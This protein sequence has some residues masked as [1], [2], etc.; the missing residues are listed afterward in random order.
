MGITICQQQI[1]IAFALGALAFPSANAIAQTSI[2][3]IVAGDDPEYEIDPIAVGNT[4]RISPRVFVSTTYD[5][6]VT[7]NPDGSEIQDFEFIVRPELV[8]SVVHRDMRFELEGY[9]EFSRFAD[10]TSENS[11]TYGVSGNFSHSPS[12]NQRLSIDAGYARQKENRGDPEAR[13]EEAP[14]PRLFDNTFASVDYRLSGGRVLLALEAAYSNLDAISSVDAD[15]D[16]ETYAGSATAGYRVSG[17]VYAT[18]TGF[19]TARDFRLPATPIDPDRDATTYGAQIGVNFI[20]SERLRGRARLGMF[21]F[22]PSDASLDGRTGFSADVSLTYLPRRRLALIL[23][24]FNGDVATFRRGAQA[25][26]DTRVSLT[27]QME[28]RHNFYART[29]LRWVQNRFIGS[30]IEENILGYNLALEF[31]ASRNLS[32]IAQVGESDRTSDDPAQEFD[33]FR[34]SIAAR[35]RF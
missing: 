26:T 15:R 1:G 17:P 12:A 21:R 2:A 11:D 22:D 25:R 7:A 31:L 18:V 30:G 33:R 29:G 14:G 16:F 34:T 23:E 3:P 24:A 4:L 6:N 32:F 5:D 19:V 10:L 28:I 8:A 20:E 13:D 9:G 35:F 27:G